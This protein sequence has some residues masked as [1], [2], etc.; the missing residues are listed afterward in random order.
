MTDRQ[1][2]LDIV[3][4][5]FLGPRREGPRIDRAID[6]PIARHRAKNLSLSRHLLL[7]H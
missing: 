2:D 4:E 7:L 6:G 5:Q 1:L 3:K